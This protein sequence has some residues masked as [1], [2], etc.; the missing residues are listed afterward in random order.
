[1][2]LCLAAAVVYVLYL[3]F[4][5]LDPYGL[6]SDSVSGIVYRRL[7]WESKS[8]FPEGYVSAFEALHTRPVLLYW[9]FYA[10][11]HQFL[12]SFQLE[13][14]CI[15]FLK[16]VV[17][18]C[19]LTKLKITRAA[20]FFSLLLVI[21]CLT[22]EARY[23]S[24]W[25]S[26][27]YA[28]F[29]I[30]IFLTLIMRLSLE[31]VESTRERAWR[32]GV[33]L[34]PAA[35]LGYGSIRL[36]LFLYLPLVVL[37]VGRV[38]LRYFQRLPNRRVDWMLCAVSVAALLV[39]ILFYG[40]FSV[41]HPGLVATSVKIAGIDKWLSWEVLS[42]QIKA[43]LLCFGLA[44]RGKITSLNGIRFLLSVVIAAVEVLS[45]LWLLRN[46]S[47]RAKA[48][49]GYVALAA[50]GVA[51][52]QI[53]IGQVA[54]TR[55]DYVAAL[56]IP[57]LCG[58]AL[59]E[60]MG[61]GEKLDVKPLAAVAAVAV[62]LLGTRAGV[63]AQIYTGTLPLEQVADYAEENGYQYAVGGYWTT[64]VLT[65]Y[66]DGRLETWY[67]GGGA[68]IAKMTPYQ[69][70][71]DTKLFTQERLGERG[72]LILTDSEEEMVFEEDS[73]VATLLNEHAQKVTE[74]STYNLYAVTENPYTLIEKIKQGPAGLPAAGQTEKTDWPWSEGFTLGANATLNDTGELVSDG[75]T[76]GI[77]L[78]GPYSA[79][80]PGVYDI[81]L[82]YT[83]DAVGAAPKGTFDVALDMQRYATTTF[84]ADQTSVTL[85]DV[86]IE[87]GHQFETRV[88][89][90]AEMAIRVQSIHYERVE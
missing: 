54:I 37:D 15:F 22:D 31:E 80:V 8:F 85:E 36:I 59:S 48:F 76:G 26:D 46:G 53:L 40:L 77:L 61:K 7:S 19:F 29:E 16:L 47:K 39:N 82:N 3:I 84:T 72:L 23:V 17:I 6:D 45:I 13:N 60:W 89:I 44:G 74:I 63:E 86:S 69:W 73:Y 50:L 33:I 71:I 4:V 75:T 87:A 49:M 64:R 68:G 55:Y 34:L 14:A 18:Y 83:V 11:T 66:T 42:S 12:L 20:R 79:T 90:P 25:P 81:T 35:L 78:Y 88:M 28:L 5:K 2:A 21:T 24:F 43:L 1:M 58:C 10:I 62:L 65:G 32:I 27:A 57:M 30:S 70:M 38:L 41:R 52:Y 51:A 67:S 9:L 56:T